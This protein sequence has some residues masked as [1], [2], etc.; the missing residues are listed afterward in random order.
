MKK[1]TARLNANTPLISPTGI[2]NK[3]A[4][5]HKQSKDNQLFF[6]ILLYTSNKEK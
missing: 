3:P 5:Q 1:W 2:K 4:A 6:N